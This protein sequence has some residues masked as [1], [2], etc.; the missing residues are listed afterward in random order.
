MF[1]LVDSGVSLAL[2]ARVE[3]RAHNFS[4]TRPRNWKHHYSKLVKGMRQVGKKRKS[5]HEPRD[6]GCDK[7]FPPRRLRTHIM[8]EHMH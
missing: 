3:T 4:E 6:K 2:E 1:A 8:Q 5:K 7:T